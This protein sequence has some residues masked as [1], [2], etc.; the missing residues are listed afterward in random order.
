MCPDIS[1]QAQGSGRQA[2][3][4]RSGQLFHARRQVGGLSDG[5]D[6]ALTLVGHRRQDKV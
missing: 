4:A 2:A 3:A 6:P 5:G 1:D